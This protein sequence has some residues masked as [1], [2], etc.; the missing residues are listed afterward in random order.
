MEKTKIHKNPQNL[1]SVVKVLQVKYVNNCRIK[2][3]DKRNF[4]LCP[5]KSCRCHP[6]VQVIYFLL[7]C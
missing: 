1:V 2:D 4:L 6:F 5:V 7:Y 3:I